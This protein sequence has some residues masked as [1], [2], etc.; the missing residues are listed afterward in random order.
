[1]GLEN[2]VQGTRLGDIDIVERGA[3]ATNEFNTID[4][5]S[6]GVAEVI[7]NYDLIISF[8]KGECR[9]RANVTGSS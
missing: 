8:E 7:D 4:S 6:R 9:E 5:F 3:L 2:L 1:M